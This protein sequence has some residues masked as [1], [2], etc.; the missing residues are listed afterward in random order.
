MEVISLF[1]KMRSLFFFHNYGLILRFLTIIEKGQYSIF[2]VNRKSYNLLFLTFEK[3][4]FKKGSPTVV[5]VGGQ[6]KLKL[7]YIIF[8]H[9]PIKREPK[10]CCAHDRH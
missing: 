10:I 8:I 9:V 4:K 3:V 5:K 7:F 1:V 6:C 2:S